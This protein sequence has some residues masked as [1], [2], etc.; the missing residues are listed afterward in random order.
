MV[1]FSITLN[2]IQPC[3]PARNLLVKSPV[4]LPN[5]IDGVVA[6]PIMTVK[7]VNSE[8]MGV[9]SIAI[10]QNIVTLDVVLF[11]SVKFTFIDHSSLVP[12]TWIIGDVER[13]NGP[14]I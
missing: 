1:P 2:F 4:G 8:D 7:H 11:V 9:V 5:K 10:A 14:V 12:G 13:P 6:S 3:E